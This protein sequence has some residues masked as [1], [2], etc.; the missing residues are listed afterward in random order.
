MQDST[1]IW[2]FL[3]REFQDDHMV[4]YLYVCGNTRSPQTSI[5]KIMEITTKVFCPPLEEY[6]VK[7]I[8][9]AYLDMKKRQYIN[10]QIKVKS[11]Y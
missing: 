9:K 11:I 7:Q 3:S 2:K 5:N 8:V 10:R 1:I 4:I 6:Y